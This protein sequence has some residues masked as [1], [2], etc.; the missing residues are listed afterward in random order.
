MGCPASKVLATSREMMRLPGEAVFRLPPLETPDDVNL[1]QIDLMR[2]E[3]IR[4]F[5]DRVRALQP[6]FT[7]TAQNRVAVT[8]ICLALDGI[9]LAN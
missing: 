7:L 5:C 4:L 3:S 6:Q 8:R 1:P 9:P 2:F